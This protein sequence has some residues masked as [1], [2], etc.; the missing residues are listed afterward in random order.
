MTTSSYGVHAVVKSSSN[1]S[2]EALLFA[3]RSRLV[4][5]ANDDNDILRHSCG[6]SVRVTFFP[7]RTLPAVRS[8]CCTR[9]DDND[10]LPC[11][12]GGGCLSPF[13]VEAAISSLS[14][15]VSGARGTMT[16]TTSMFVRRWVFVTFFPRIN[17]LLSGRVLM[18]AEQRQRHPTAAT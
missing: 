8:Y 16:T 7:S 1:F 3:V 12:C 2:V 18:Y 14:G 5:R 9:K 10:I 15:R 6:G 17:T 13:S 4:A 11:P